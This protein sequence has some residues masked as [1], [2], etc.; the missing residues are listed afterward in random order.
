MPIS[1]ALSTHRQALPTSGLAAVSSPGGLPGVVIW[2]VPQMRASSWLPTK[3]P[4]CF[5]FLKA[6]PGAGYDQ[7]GRAFPRSHREGA[8][9]RSKWPRAQAPPLSWDP[10]VGSHWSLTPHDQ[11]SHSPCPPGDGPRGHRGRG[12]EWPGKGVR[13][14]GTV[15]PPAPP[16]SPEAVPFQIINNSLLEKQVC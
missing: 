7:T 8:G 5:Y 10:P 12:S 11:R 16:D 3:T 6:N 9:S 14:W 4:K 15:A 13:N 2:V 1:S